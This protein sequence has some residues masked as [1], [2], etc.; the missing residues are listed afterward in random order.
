[1]RVQRSYL[2]LSKPCAQYSK[3]DREQTG[4]AS[5]C[6]ALRA[7]FKHSQLYYA[8]EEQQQHQQQQQ[9]Q[10]PAKRNYSHQAPT[11]S[12]DSAN[13]IG[14]QR[15]DAYYANQCEVFNEK[16]EATRFADR[17]TNHYRQHPQANVNGNLHFDAMQNATKL[18]RHSSFRDGFVNYNHGEIE[19]EGCNFD[20][21]Q[22]GQIMDWQTPNRNNRMVPEAYY[23][24][25]KVSQWQDYG[26]ARNSE[27][28][29]QFQGCRETPQWQDS[30]DNYSYNSRSSNCLPG[31]ASAKNLRRSS[32]SL[33]SD[34][35]LYTSRSSNSSHRGE[36]KKII[37]EAQETRAIV[38]D[39]QTRI[40]V[41]LGI[42]HYRKLLVLRKNNLS[43]QPGLKAASSSASIANNSSQTLAIIYGSI[44][45]AIVDSSDMCGKEFLFKDMRGQV[46]RCVAYLIDQEWPRKV[47]R[48]KRVK[49]IC[50]S[51]SNSNDSRSL[52][53]KISLCDE[54][55]MKMGNVAARLAEKFF[56][57]CSYN[58]NLITHES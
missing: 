18:Q 53:H 56:V 45:S 35:R 11:G 19:S 38:D 3:T 42:E 47:G 9:Q 52:V 49:V 17:A 58:R 7:M 15:G 20:A 2:K 30:N 6:G 29:K 25:P 33:Y 21:I 39:N 54:N 8:N 50:Q 28:P 4:S 31:N 37:K 48:G 46:M 10:A 55:E 41:C 5:S 51:R 16:R 40:V 13:Q 27:P 14:C 44:A 57:K 36:S 43:A 1:M 32:E 24:D 23:R 12:C 34:D 22:R 26:D